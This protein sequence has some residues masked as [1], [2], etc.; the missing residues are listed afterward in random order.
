MVIILSVVAALGLALGAAWVLGSPRQQPDRAAEACWSMLAEML[1]LDY[2]PGGLLKGPYMTGKINGMTVTLDTFHQ[3]RDGRKSLM[4]RFI[5]QNEALPE[6]LDRKS[7]AKPSDDVVKRIIAQTVR[8]YVS[9]LIK[10]IGATVAAGKVRW[11]RDSSVWHPDATAQTIKRIVAICEFLCVDDS[12]QAAKLLLGYQD[13]NMPDAQRN[14]MKTLLF[15]RFPGTPECETVASEMLDTSNPEDRLSAAKALGERGT[16]TLVKM[17]MNADL[18]SSVREKA[19]SAL[20]NKNE[21]A[22]TQPLLRAVLNSANADVVR[23]A[24]GLIRRNKYRPAARLLIEIANDARTAT[25]RVCNIIDIIG[26][27]SDSSAQSALLSF[28]NHDFLMVRRRAA[29]ALGRI[30]NPSAVPFLQNCANEEAS[31]RRFRELC[32]RAVQRIQKRHGTGARSRD[33]QAEAS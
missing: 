29:S 19:L 14:Q 18:P 33:I 17:A 3:M 21:P 7:K 20:I 15:E 11:V 23:T 10:K 30:G 24:L 31:N 6:G 2:D 22:K 8:R 5:L 16:D 9:E 1:N 26:E 4:T 27:I 32:L 28:L 25:D 12:D 13:E